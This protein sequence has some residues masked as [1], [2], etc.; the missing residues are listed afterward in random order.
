MSFLVLFCNFLGQAISLKAW[1]QPQV[2]RNRIWTNQMLIK[3]LFYLSVVGQGSGGG[4]GV[5]G[6]FFFIIP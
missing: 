2:F 5:V 6:F 1:L 3:M 4:E